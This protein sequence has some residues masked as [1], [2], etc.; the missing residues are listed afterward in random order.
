VLTL[1]IFILSWSLFIGGLGGWL[2]WSLRRHKKMLLEAKRGKPI[3]QMD[4]SKVGLIAFFCSFGPL[5]VFFIGGII[6]FAMSG[7]KSAIV[8]I[9]VFAVMEA[10]ILVFGFFIIRLARKNLA[11]VKQK[12]QATVLEKE[13]YRYWQL[14]PGE[15]VGGHTVIK[16]FATFELANGTRLRLD[17][18]VTAYEMLCE[19]ATGTLYYKERNGEKWFIGFDPA[20]G[21]L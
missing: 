14:S 17:V 1:Y 4:K 20:G 9:V 10:F 3:Q 7:Y 15:D 2:A 16:Y 18:F 8:G 13:K 19:H 21:I 6:Y 5:S 11:Q 12:V